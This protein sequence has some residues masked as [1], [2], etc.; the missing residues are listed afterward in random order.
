LD[1]GNILQHQERYVRK[2]VRELNDFD[3]LYFE[4]QNE[5]WAEAP[6]LVF[7][8][9]PFGPEEDWRSQAQIVSQKSNA[10]QRRVAEWIK[11]EESSLSKKHLISQNISNFDYPITDPDPNISIFN[12]H[13][14]FPRAVYQNYYLDRAIGLNETGFAG[15]ADST[16][17]QQAWRFLMAGGSLFSHLDYSFS[18]GSEDGSDTAYEAP[19]GGSPELRDQLHVLKSFFE[20]LDF[21]KLKPDFQS[22]IASP[23]ASTLALSDRQS[24]WVIYLEPMA[25]KS[26]DLTLDL[27]EGEYQAEW[28][29]VVSGKALGTMAVENNQLKVPDGRFDKAVVIRSR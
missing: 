28:I 22:V 23:G 9:N 12:F 17:R 20:G 27:P 7:N 11:E 21:V 8:R 16:Y 19:G 2:I 24:L 25:L 6:D 15:Q 13:Y 1:N 4:I 5:P 10:W 14:A 3:N 26:Y 29:D 18:V